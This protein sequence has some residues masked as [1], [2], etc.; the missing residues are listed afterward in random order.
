MYDSDM[1]TVIKTPRLLPYNIPQGTVPVPENK[2]IA[3][4]VLS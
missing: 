1:P 4:T 3:G 2:S